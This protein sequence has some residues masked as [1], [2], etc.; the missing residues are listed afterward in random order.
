[1]ENITENEKRTLTQKLLEFQK[2]G[3]LSYGK[4]LTEQLE[5]ASKSESRNAYKKYVEEQIIMN[6]QKIKEIDDKLQ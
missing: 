4:Y 6:N 5:F 1:M 2:T 3:L